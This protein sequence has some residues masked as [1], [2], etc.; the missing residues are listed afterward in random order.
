MPIGKLPLR[1]FIV[2]VIAIVLLSGCTMVPTRGTLRS[3]DVE[4]LEIEPEKISVS[5]QVFRI[6]IKVGNPN[7]EDLPVAALRGSIV[8]DGVDFTNIDIQK[9]FIVV[10]RGDYRVDVSSKTTLLDA[11]RDIQKLIKNKKTALN[12]RLFGTVK[13]DRPF[14]RDLTFQG[15]GSV[16][17]KQK[18]EDQLR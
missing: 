6:R 11:T 9:P 17:L 3:P 8:L 18:L 10:S 4:I 5:Q 12:Y 13:V 16:D 7:N 1:R 2:A 14:A 15:S